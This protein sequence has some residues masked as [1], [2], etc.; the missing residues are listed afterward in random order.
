M[1]HSIDLLAASLEA[2]TAEIRGVRE[3][4]RDLAATVGKINAWKDGDMAIPGVNTR[5]TIVERDAAVLRRVAWIVLVSVSG[6]V[7]HALFRAVVEHQPP[8]TER[9][10]P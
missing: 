8:T 4:I 7:G 3:D 10:S 6:L 5:L 9:A 1:P 2:Q